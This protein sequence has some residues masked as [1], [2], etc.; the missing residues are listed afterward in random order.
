MTLFS[1]FSQSSKIDF[2]HFFSHETERIFTFAGHNDKPIDSIE[3]FKI[4]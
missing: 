2:N 1:D 4:S 3:S